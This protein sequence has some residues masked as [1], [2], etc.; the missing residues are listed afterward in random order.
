MVTVAKPSGLVEL[1][2]EQAYFGLA[3]MCRSCVQ[4]NKVL[5]CDCKGTSRQKIIKSG[6]KGKT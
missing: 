1:Q 2:A 4:G 3:E 6:G 5:D